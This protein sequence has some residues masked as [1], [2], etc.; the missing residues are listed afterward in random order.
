[1]FHLQV[2]QQVQVERVLPIVLQVV[3]PDVRLVQRLL[4]RHRLARLIHRL[5]RLRVLLRE[6]GVCLQRRLGPHGLGR[7]SLVAT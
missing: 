5:L 6:L 4:R 3:Q 1:M 2:V 7:R